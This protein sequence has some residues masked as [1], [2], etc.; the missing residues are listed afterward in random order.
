[1]AIELKIPVNEEKI[2]KLK[3]GDE[4]ILSG[5]VVTA[6]DMAHEWLCS[7]IQAYFIEKLKNGAVYHCGPI[8][9][10]SEHGW[11]FV[12]AGPTTSIREE[13]FQEQI[14]RDYGVR[15]VLGKGG[16]GSKTLKA[17][18]KYGAVY[19]HLTGGSAA[20]IAESV[21]KVSDVKKLSEFGVPE[22]LWIVELEKLKAVVT[23]DAH[24]NSLH[25]QIS[26]DSSAVKKNLIY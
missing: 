13:P 22:A 5:T 16:M 24:G 19:L 12:S 15:F 11:K 23:M 17:L 1:M 9:A 21:K 10:E 26:E 2:R 14:L 6:R 18:K 20:L 3:I 7:E 25:D 8:V 4:L